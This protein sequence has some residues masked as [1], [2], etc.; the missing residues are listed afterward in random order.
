MWERKKNKTSREMRDKA[1]R[2][3]TSGAGQLK[4]HVDAT[5]AA[6]TLNVLP[7]APGSSLDKK[8]A[9]VRKHKAHAS[10]VPRKKT[11]GGETP[12]E[13]APC[14][15]YCHSPGITADPHRTAATVKSSAPSLP[16]SCPE[17]AQSYLALIPYYLT[18]QGCF[19]EYS[20][21]SHD[22]DPPIKV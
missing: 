16:L 12:L 5:P 21:H 10:P 3:I 14:K 9:Q 15:G 22:Q 20:P 19:T 4:W 8:A 7:T 2:A 13:K 11:T 6:M 18:H 1:G 17:T